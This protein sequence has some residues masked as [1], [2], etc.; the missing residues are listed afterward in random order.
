[1]DRASLTEKYLAVLAETAPGARE[2]LGSQPDSA[3]LGSYYRGRY[4]P[5]PFFLGHAER[6]RL[7]ADLENLRAAL[8]ALPDRLFGGDFAAFARAVGLDDV[9]VS[10]VLR[11]RGGPLTRQ[12]R[13]DLYVDETGGFKLLELNIGSAVAGM[14]NADMCRALLEHPVLAGFAR[15]HGLGF[16]DSMRE[17]VDNVLVECGVRPGDRPV[18]ALTDS[19]QSYR[20]MASYMALLC[21]RWGE[22]GLT[23]LPCH[24][25]QLEA[26]DGRV[27]L[28]EVPV[29][30]VFRT[31]LIGDLRTSAAASELMDPILDAAERGEVTIFTPME[32]AAYASKGALALLSDEGNRHLFS[33]GELESLDRILPWTRMVRPGPVTLEGGA[34]VDLVRY[35]LSHQRELVLK[36]TSLAGGEGVLLGWA[37]GLG[38]REWRERILAALDGP[39]VIQRRI[40]PAPEL[41]PDETGRLRPWTALW[42]V[43]TVVNGYGGAFIR[44]T[45]ATA[46]DSVVNVA[47][48]AYVGAVLHET[49]PST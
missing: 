31:F 19:P 36:P 39:F 21:E 47:T 9:Q 2:L 49:A 35:A 12:T 16:V 46:G 7:H 23:A 41:L 8:A 4:L 33:A 6:V 27:W 3:L 18:V 10:A 44:A 25:G 1:M 13:A 38:P 42:G 15:E 24:I 48:G 37:D 34:R 43:F 30:I 26:R 32:S 22:L 14:D 45:P 5:R 20:E 28:G 29:D 11:G 40:R 17:Q